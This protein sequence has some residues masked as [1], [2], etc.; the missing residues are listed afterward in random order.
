MVAV[1]VWAVL[2]AAVTAGAGGAAVC[3]ADRSA[4]AGAAVCAADMSAGAGT[5][6]GTATCAGDGTEAGVGAAAAARDGEDEDGAVVVGEGFVVKAG[7][8]ATLAELILLALAVSV[9]TFGTWKDRS[10]TGT[11][12]VLSMVA[13]GLRTLRQSYTSTV[14]FVV[15]TAQWMAS[16]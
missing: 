7:T 12:E 4:G 15:P 9:P 6:T 10:L 2:E 16:S 1:T 14:P 13:T 8:V 3:A 11:A 5:G